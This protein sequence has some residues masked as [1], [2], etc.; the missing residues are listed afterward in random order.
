M[1]FI[2]IPGGGKMTYVP[3]LAGVREDLLAQYT[4]SQDLV[5]LDKPIVVMRLKYSWLLL[6]LTAQATYFLHRSCTEGG[7]DMVGC[8]CR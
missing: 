6:S 8:I 2:S 4:K 7:A 1:S 5:N 3:H